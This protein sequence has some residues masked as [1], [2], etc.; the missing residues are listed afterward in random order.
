MTT[1]NFTFE[2]YSRLDRRHQEI[3]TTY[4][5]ASGLTT[6][7]QILEIDSASKTRAIEGPEFLS[8]MVAGQ[9]CRLSVRLA[10]I[11]EKQATIEVEKIEAIKRK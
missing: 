4:D 9:L 10:E 8:P 2:P 7:L 5:I 6:L 1:D 11:L 3:E